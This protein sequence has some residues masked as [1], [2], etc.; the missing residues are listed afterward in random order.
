MLMAA[1]ERLISVEDRE[2]IHQA[3]FIE[4][5]SLRQIAREL[6]VA[7]KT[8]GKALA[9]AEAE[10]YRLSAARPTP[11]LEPYKPQIEELLAENKLTICTSASNRRWATRHRPRSR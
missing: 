8:I 4:R 5:K 9:S 3:Y 11:I 2:L 1:E 7:R 6:H 10:S